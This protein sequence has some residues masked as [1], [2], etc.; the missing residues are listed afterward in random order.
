[1]ATDCT[2]MA[3]P[4]LMWR[5]ARTLKTTLPAAKIVW[6]CDISCAS[7][8]W[9]RKALGDDTLI[10]ADMC[11]RK[12]KQASFVADDIYGNSVQMSREQADLDIYIAGFMCS[13]FSQ[14]GARDGWADD[15]AATFFN[16]M[17]TIVVMQPR[18]VILENVLAVANSKN[19]AR[20]ME[21]LTAVNGYRWKFIKVHAAEFGIPQD[22]ER[23]YIVG[24][25]VG[26]LSGEAAAQ[27][28]ND[29]HQ[30]IDAMKSPH[31][32]VSDWPQF[33]ADAGLPLAP[34]P[35][36][37]GVPAQPCDICDRKTPGVCTKHSCPC[38]RCKLHGMKAKKCAWRGHLAT[39]QVKHCK[40]M[41]KYLGTWRTVKKDN[42]LKAP[43]NYYQLAAL[44]EMRVPSV[45]QDSPRVRSC[46]VA[47][48]SA[49]NL[50]VEN[51]ICNSSQA[52]DRTRPRFD[53]LVPTLT[54]T[55]G[56]LFALKYGCF[57]SPRQVFALQGFDPNTLPHK[58]FTETSLFMLA[59]MGMTAPV[60]GSI[61]MAVVG[62]L[63]Q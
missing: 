46:L 61:M 27:D 55:C 43:P 31:H 20:L 35:L 36:G 6:T 54:S 60:I 47:W 14:A 18:F 38:T 41:R 11:A 58:D 52:V 22:R 13:P 34:L 23:Y 30:R 15:A 42:A 8:E 44:K 59:G 39:W 32:S 2:G 24:K 19:V 63:Q 16:C 9:I 48:S 12:F 56:R 21:S 4:E 45:I 26:G 28:V 10:L 37:I 29:L 57:L 5:L 40:Q 62:Q 50:F 17:R 51:A 7:R 25:Q 1:M 53:G 33:L 49:Q 3:T